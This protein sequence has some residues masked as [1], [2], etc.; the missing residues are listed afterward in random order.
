LPAPVKI[1]NPAERHPRVLVAPLDWGLGHATRCI[2][3]IK[4][5]LNQR[6]N[7]VIAATD[8]QETLL[9]EEFPSLTFV[10]L[11]GYGI[12]YDKNRALTIFRLLCSIPKILIRIKQENAWLRRFAAQESLDLVISDNRYGLTLPGTPCIFV[13]HQLL[14]KTPF[15]PYFDRLLQKMNYRLVRKF[16]RCWVPDNRDAGLAGELS[17]PLH[18]PSTPTHYIGW[19]SRFGEPVIRS[20]ETILLVLLSGPEPQRSLLEDRIVRQAQEMDKAQMHDNRMG[21]RLVIVRGLPKGGP[22]LTGLPSWITVHEH[23]PAAKLEALIMQVRLV[24]ARSGYSTIM[25]LERLGKQALLIPTPG[26][27]EQ[28][29]LGKYL[30]EKG[31]APCVKQTAFSL[32]EAFRLAAAHTDDRPLR[33]FSPENLRQEIKNVLTPA[34][35]IPPQ[36]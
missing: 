30:A 18:M 33:T 32:N 36:S 27:T 2:P 21:L 24:I 6:C 20:G 34:L 14:I 13:T 10:E 3:I 17:H 8:V 28:E 12:K 7:V 26:Q 22:R 1:N 31:W 29:Y 4:E 19:L 23:L 16:S 9:R 25:D 5:L 11:R 35:A 15:G